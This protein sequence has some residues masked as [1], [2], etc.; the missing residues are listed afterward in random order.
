MVKNMKTN[1]LFKVLFL[2]FILILSLNAMGDE[3]TVDKYIEEIRVADRSITERDLAFGK[4][5]EQILVRLTGNSE[6]AKLPKMAAQRN[7]AAVFIQSYT[8]VVHS[9]NGQEALFLRIKFDAQCIERLMG[10]T[11]SQV[12]KQSA[13]LVWLAVRDDSNKIV[14]DEGG[15]FAIALKAAGTEA[16]LNILLPSMDLQDLSKLTVEDICSQNIELIKEASQRY[17]V[18][19][20]AVGCITKTADKNWDSQWILQTKDSRFNWGFSSNN[21]DNIL[22]DAMHHIM[23]SIGNVGTVVQPKSVVLRVTG[24]KD[25][26]QYAEVV[27]YLRQISP[28]SNIAL[29][30]INASE[31][32]L[33][34]IGQRGQQEL[35]VA[36]N[37]QS[38]LAP[39]KERLEGVDLNYYWNTTP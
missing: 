2:V 38:K 26:G 22:S 8:Y 20:I 4:A 37:S 39:D 28:N 11:V 14:T 7:N 16:N 25:L 18:P 33:S 12:D 10:Q 23:Q 6:V 21:T 9:D 19:S 36:L 34:I 30:S 15:D 5:L 24:V 31:V 29:I 13:T 27:K 3:P 32:K 35:L 1:K 17:G